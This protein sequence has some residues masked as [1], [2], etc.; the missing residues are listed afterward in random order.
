VRL[1]AALVRSAG[2]RAADHEARYVL[3]LGAASALS[4]TSAATLRFRAASGGAAC[5]ELSYHLA[6]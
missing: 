1:D 2:L 4:A 3:D 6:F 5:A